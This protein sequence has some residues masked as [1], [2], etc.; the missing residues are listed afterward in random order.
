M[1]C[2]SVRTN[3]QYNGDEDFVSKY[4]ISKFFSFVYLFEVQEVQKS[5][6]NDNVIR[7]YNQHSKWQRRFYLYLS[8]NGSLYNW[9]SETSF[10]IYT[11]SF[12]SFW[13]RKE[14]RWVVLTDRSVN[15]YGLRFNDSS[16]R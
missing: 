11:V 15:T 4:D 6:M 9:L 7:F 13:L 3:S 1:V 8:Y 5:W 16:L 12:Y 10:T 2:Q 14:R